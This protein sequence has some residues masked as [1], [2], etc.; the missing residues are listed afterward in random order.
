MPKKD[1]AFSV[2][3]QVSQCVLFINPF[4]HF[5]IIYTNYLYGPIQLYQATLLSIIEF[6]SVI[7]YL[8]NVNY[9]TDT[10]WTCMK[11]NPKERRKLAAECVWPVDNERVTKSCQSHSRAQA[12]FTVCSTKNVRNFSIFHP[13]IKHPC[14]P[15]FC[16]F[17]LTGVP[18]FSLTDYPLLLFTP[19]NYLSFLS[20][21]YLTTS[22]HIMRIHLVWIYSTSAK[23]ESYVLS[24]AKFGLRE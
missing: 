16:L 20:L 3:A 1:A 6:K 11:K 24:S 8:W 21:K 4:S 9:Q 15:V 22:I 2:S 14:Q 19:T 17:P 7:H 13:F 10:V 12:I 23:K 5:W 18:F